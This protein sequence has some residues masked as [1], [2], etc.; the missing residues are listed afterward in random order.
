MRCG[1]SCGCRNGRQNGSNCVDS[2][3]VSPALCLSMDAMSGGMILT[4]RAKERKC[5]DG[6]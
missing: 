5:H 3:L 6:D 4:S 2:D 1:I